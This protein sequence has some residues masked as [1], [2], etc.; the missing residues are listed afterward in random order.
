[1]K[2]SYKKMNNKSHKLSN[3]LKTTLLA[4]VVLSLSATCAY[5]SEITP[6]NVTYLVNRERTYYGLDPLRVNLDLNSAATSKSADMVERDYFEHFAYGLSPWDFMRSSNY[7]Y[8]YAGENL[9]MDFQTAEGMVKAWMNSNMHR[10][11]ILSPDFEEMGIGVVKGAYTE[12]GQTRET[13][14]V[15]NMFG[16]KKT[17]VIK[18]IDKVVATFNN[19]FN[20]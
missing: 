2:K 19:I 10:A 15:N 9:A 11:N 3:A 6:E 5:A 14:M 13:V 8:L 4:G 7:D 16:R 1:M 17:V 18:A 20:K 12:N